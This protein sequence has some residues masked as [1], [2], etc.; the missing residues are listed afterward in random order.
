MNKSISPARMITAGLL[1]ALVT[2]S[3]LAVQ[4][5]DAD[6][7]IA[8]SI[9]ASGGLEKLQ[10]VDSAKITGKFLAQGMEFPFTMT[11]KRPGMMRIDA[12][13]M[14]STMVQCFGGDKG[15]TIN[16]MTGSTAAQP[17]SEVEE[18]SF[19][20]Q[21]D[22]DGILV[23]Y[24][25][26]GYT[27]EYIGEADVEGTPTYQLKVDTNTGI[28]LNMF[29]DTE[30]FL[31]IKTNSKI[32]LD[33]SEFETQTYMSDF[34]EVDGLTM[35]FS[36]ETRSGDTVM[37]QIMMEKIEYGVE[38]DDS[39]FEMPEAPTAPKTPELGK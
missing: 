36:I 4:A 14:G 22:M 25:K 28:V 6:E 30:F 11:Q 33:E 27:V 18:M 37:N 16:P 23:D 13:V 7:L 39:L 26:K 19:R 20:L 32:S 3:P 21:S 12:N 34:Q 38:I 29:M 1:L 31:N 17:M 2:I 35:P 24:A 15:W 5:M 10:A 9:E 8:K